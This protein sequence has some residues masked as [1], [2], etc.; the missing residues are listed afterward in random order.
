MFLF[1]YKLII[2]VKTKLGV[3]KSTQIL[4]ILKVLFQ[5]KLDMNVWKNLKQ[6]VDLCRRFTIPNRHH[7]D[8]FFYVDFN[9]SR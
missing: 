7:F 6:A 1:I 9:Y 2:T 5:P 4:S 3:C 8:L